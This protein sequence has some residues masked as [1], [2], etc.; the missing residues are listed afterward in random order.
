[1]QQNIKI[2]FKI[3]LSFEF[4]LIISCTD[5]TTYDEYDYDSYDYDD[6]TDDN[7]SNFR[8]VEM[9]NLYIFICLT[10][11]TKKYIIKEI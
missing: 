2:L 1:M 3:L 8:T 9:G 10:Q 5:I 11:I 6:Y 4:V 7:Y